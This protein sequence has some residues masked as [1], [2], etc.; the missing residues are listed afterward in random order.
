MESPVPVASGMVEFIQQHALFR[1]GKRFA[2]LAYAS[3]EAIFAA[4]LFLA[5][6]GSSLKRVVQVGRG[7]FLTRFVLAPRRTAPLAQARTRGRI[8]AAGHV[9]SLVVIE[10]V[11]ERDEIVL[12]GSH[13]LLQAAEPLAPHL[14]LIQR[15]RHFRRQSRQ[16]SAASQP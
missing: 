9:L 10:L 7:F 12:F 6:Q 3:R 15:L 1:F 8:L 14:H 16:P 2:T 11:V 5:L 13:R 4:C